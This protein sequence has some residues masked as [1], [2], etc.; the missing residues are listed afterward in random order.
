LHDILFF[1]IINNVFYLGL[2]GASVVDDFELGTLLELGLRPLL[3]D[4]GEGRLAT[5]MVALHDALK[6]HIERRC[7]DDDTIYQMVEARLIE[8]G[9]F[10]P[11]HAALQEVFCYSGVNNSIDGLF[12]LLGSHQE[13]CYFCLVE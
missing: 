6:A 7:H 12:I 4:P 13:V 11:L 1:Y 3:V 10:H 2:Q 5:N 9:A 8:D